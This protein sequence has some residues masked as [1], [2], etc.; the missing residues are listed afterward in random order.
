LEQLY[1][2][3]DTSKNVQSIQLISKE[4]LMRQSKAQNTGI[5]DEEDENMEEDDDQELFNDIERKMNKGEIRFS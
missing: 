5:Q 4:G 2:P 1:L 3:G